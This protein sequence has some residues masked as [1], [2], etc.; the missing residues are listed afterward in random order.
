[1]KIKKI[2]NPSCYE[3]FSWEDSNIEKNLRGKINKILETLPK[4][5]KTIID[6]GC[7]NGAITNELGKKY[8]VTGVDRSVNALKF[9]KTKTILSPSDKINIPDKSYD[10]VFSSEL[11][12]HLEDQSFHDT[13]VEMKRISRRYIFITVPNSETIEKDLIK[14][15]DCGWIYN[16]SYHLRSLNLEKLICHFPEFKIIKSFEYGTG[17]RGYNRH[18]TILKHKLSP[19]SSWIPPRWTH[20]SEWKT[21]CPKCETSFIYKYKFNLISYLCDFA[22]IFLSPHKPYWLFVLLERRF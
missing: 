8:D 5:V 21:F 7:G 22:N 18:L 4:N 17:K 11:L 9:V 13:I 15:P 2:N 1:M 6:I 10:M 3:N 14:C 19:S 20:K 12:E 16:R